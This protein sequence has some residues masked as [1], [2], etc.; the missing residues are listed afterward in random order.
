MPPAA[1]QPA[2]AEQLFR[3]V[4]GTGFVAV[5]APAAAPAGAAP[6]GATAVAGATVVAAPPAAPA[7]PAYYPAPA[8][9]GGVFPSLAGLGLGPLVRG[10]GD[11]RAAYAP[12]PADVELAPLAA[13]P[14]A[15]HA[16]VFAADDAAV[17]RA[18]APGSAG[19]YGGGAI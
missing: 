5:G 12:V 17:A 15:G 4:P 13:R 3:F 18:H 10:W 6:A 8:P 7:A 14:A 16:V 9:A 2:P 19:A 1:P 11:R